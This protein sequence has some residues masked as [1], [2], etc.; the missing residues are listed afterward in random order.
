MKILVP[1]DGSKYSL[2]AVE[3]IASRDALIGTDPTVELLNVTTP[4]PAHVARAVGKDMIRRY[5]E[6]EADK[7]LKPSL[8]VLHKA[9]LTAH[10][11]WRAGHA[12]DVIAAVADKHEVDLIVMGARGH[13]ALAGL[14]IGSVTNKVLAQTRRPM[15]VVRDKPAPRGESLKVGIAVDGS[16][17]GRAAVK[18]VLRHGE[19][20]GT[21]PALTVIHV[22]PDY[23]EAVMPD[24]AGIALPAFDSEEVKAMQEK[25]YESVFAP[26]RK[27]LAKA[28]VKADEARLVGSAGDV[29][30]DYAKSRKLDVLVMGSHGH[31]GFKAAVLGSV[32]TRVAAQCGTPLL[33]VREG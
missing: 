17:Y 13:G 1:I 22:V 25:A 14:I 15:L 30:A 8:A 11:T 12:G 20:F 33:L 10:A 9:G 3:F 6:D 7:V 31:G 26:I 18:Y 2:A 21:S 32:A 5:H 29:I 4:I 16:K 24:M 19:L 27:L 28:K 23:S